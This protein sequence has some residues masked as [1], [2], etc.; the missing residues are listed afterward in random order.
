[1]LERTFLHLP[2]VGKKTEQ[3]IWRAGFSDWEQVWRS[4]S[5][6]VPVREVL[7]KNRQRSLFE[8]RDSVSDD[9]RSIAW[10]DCLD[11]SRNAVRRRDYQFFTES[12]SPSNHWRL[13]DALLSDALYLDIE[14]TGLSHDHHYVTVI[15]ALCQG[16]FYQWVWPESLDE[17][18]ELID[19][20][21]AT[22]TFN[23]KRFDIPFLLKHFKAIPAPKAHVDLL[24]S[25]RAAGISGG[26]KAAERFFELRR[27]EEIRELDG[28]DAVIAWCDGLYGSARSFRQLLKYNRA[29]V[30]LM[31]HLAAS[32]Y[33]YLRTRTLEENEIPRP[34]IT[35]VRS[36]GRKPSSHSRLRQEWRERRPFLGALSPR[37]HEQ[38]GRDP[39]VVGIDL[40]AKPD[41]PTGWA[42]CI[43]PSTT[44][45]VLFD[46]DEILSHTLAAQPDIVS[47]DAPLSLPRGRVSVSDN[48]PCRKSGG[49]VRDAERILWSRGIRVYPALI[50]QMQGLTKRGI[51]LTKQLAEH[52][53]DVIESYPGAAQ[54]ILNIPRKK[55]DESLLRRGL[56]QFGYNI[57]GEKS[58]DE[59][60]AIT[61]A[62]VAQ[63]YL[64]EEYEEI[65]ADDEGYMVIPRFRGMSWGTLSL[66][67]QIVSLVG[68]PGAGK[69]TLAQT[70]SRRLAWSS[71]ILGN[72]LR[73]RA[74][75]D[76][77]LD[78]L[79]ARGNMAPEDLVESVLRDAVSS[80][81]DTS[82][83]VDG[84]PRHKDQL[85][86][87]A[88]LFP[89]WRILHLDLPSRLAEKRI[90]GRATCARCGHLRSSGTIDVCP[91]C[92]ASTWNT[93]SED[94]RDQI[95]A[96]RLRESSSQVRGLLRNA[97]RHTVYTVN[98]AQP[99]EKV[100]DLAVRALM[101]TRYAKRSTDA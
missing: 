51:D 62:L 40:R 80:S 65:G 63:F 69:T 100:V 88:E 26:Q 19:S 86:L 23:G 87:A 45:R 54:D 57:R 72:E 33:K 73:S 84:F 16:K 85:R 91:T 83:V 38:F 92:G 61:S 13:L 41:N 2:G 24:Y 95:I 5:S 42:L 96:S 27:A 34:R 35:R 9:P 44:T 66:H 76:P 14:T 25:V 94:E 50:R 82:V 52:G 89:N 31:P 78:E 93:R 32:L 90:R 21:P 1:M 97:P 4:L 49:I 60:D 98:A 81:Q 10:L 12:L 37:I 75:A 20:A 29:D 53:I 59:L 74:E 43:G 46:D 67:R 71:F 56:T 6:G 64:A 79:L 55:L 99:E 7:A 58:H 17:L 18:A 101:R 39:V 22:I 77:D 28:Q 30:E 36:L 68:L 3:R 8:Q 47:I 48:S 15:G 70:L 11:E